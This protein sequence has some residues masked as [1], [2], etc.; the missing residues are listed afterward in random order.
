M[1]YSTGREGLGY[2]ENKIFMSQH[3]WLNKQMAQKEHAT[4]EAMKAWNGPFCEHKSH[5]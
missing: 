4:I 5:S 3:M 2:L 1:S